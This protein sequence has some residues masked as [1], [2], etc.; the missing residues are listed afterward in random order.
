VGGDLVVGDLDL[1][2]LVV[3]HDQFLGRIL[4]G[5]QQRGEQAMTL[6]VTCTIGRVEGVFDDPHDDALFV[7]LTM[8]G[9]RVDLGQVRSV[10]QVSKRFDAR[11]RISCM[12]VYMIHADY[13]H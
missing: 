13:S 8:V 3:E 12:H 1:P 11:H 4:L 10:R 7:P 5:V 2:A 9:G 6:A